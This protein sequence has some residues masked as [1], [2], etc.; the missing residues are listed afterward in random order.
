MIAF[1][2]PLEYEA[3]PKQQDFKVLVYDHDEAPENSEQRLKV[4]GDGPIFR[5]N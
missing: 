5:L 3:I 2:Q 4:F 1:L